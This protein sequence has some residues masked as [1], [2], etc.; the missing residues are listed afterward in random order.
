[1][2]FLVDSATELAMI[3]KIFEGAIPNFMHTKQIWGFGLLGPSGS[4]IFGLQW[5]SGL[6]DWVRSGLFGGCNYKP[7]LVYFLPHFSL[8]FIYQ[9]V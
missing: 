7:R 6:K 5:L 4:N 9:S 2:A 1:M 8:Q 3:H